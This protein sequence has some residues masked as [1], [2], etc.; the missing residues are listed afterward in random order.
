[1][2][3]SF[4][5]VKSASAG[6]IPLLYDNFIDDKDDRDGDPES[7]SA[8]DAFD[9]SES[10]SS[11][12]CRFSIGQLPIWATAECGDTHSEGSESGQDMV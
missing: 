3:G 7:V 4:P 1:M 8:L 11:L 9:D 2:D 5:V 10:H 12:D 6:H